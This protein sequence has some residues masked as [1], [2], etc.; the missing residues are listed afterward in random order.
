MLVLAGFNH[1]DGYAN[2]VSCLPNASLQNG[3]SIQ[4]SSDFTDGF[5]LVLILHDR[6]AGDHAQ[7][8]YLGHGGDELLCHAM[9]EVLVLRVGADVREGENGNPARIRFIW[10]CWV[11]L[12]RHDE[13][14]DC[15]GLG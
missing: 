12:P 4:L 10:G 7:L 2:M 1:L 14:I 8:S 13:S 3:P 9:R 6:G 15:E 5:R 11:C